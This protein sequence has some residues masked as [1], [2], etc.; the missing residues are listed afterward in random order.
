MNASVNR[1]TGHTHTHT[2]TEN[3]TSDTNTHTHTTRT[4]PRT[5]KRTPLT[6]TEQRSKVA[7]RG[8]ISEGGRKLAFT[9]G[10]FTPKLSCTS[11]SSLYSLLYLHCSHYCMY[12]CTTNAQNTTPIRPPLW[13]P[14]TIQYWRWQYRVELRRLA[15]HHASVD[16]RH[17]EQHGND[18]VSG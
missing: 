18:F 1:S 4:T 15:A 17:I 12:V 5:S 3:N 16:T 7:R 6:N 9:R 14:D 11:Q 2:P 13:M 8:T 10:S